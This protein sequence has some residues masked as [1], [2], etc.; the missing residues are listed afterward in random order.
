MNSDR[1]AHLLPDWQKSFPALLRPVIMH[2]EF[3]IAAAEFLTR[4]A[5][6]AGCERASL[7]FA[8]G[9][10]VKICA[11]SGI[12]QEAG[13]SI[14]PEVAAAMEE[15]LLQDAALLYPPATTGFPRIL[16]AHAELA[17]R[18]AVSHVLTVP[19]VQDTE[20]IGAITLE[21]AD[22]TNFLSEYCEVIETLAADAG[23]IL[24]LKW[25]LEQP[26]RV[27][28][29]EVLRHCLFGREGSMGHRMYFA[30]AMA[31]LCAL[32]LFMVPMSIAVTGQARLEADVQRILTAPID[33]Y[34]KEVRVRA[35]DR[36]KEHQ[37]LAELDGEALRGQQ[38]RLQAEIAQ[39]ENALMESMIRSDRAQVGIRRAR[40]DE[41]EA[42]K[43]LVD[44][45]LAQ[46]RLS[47]P[48]DGVV[49]KGDLSQLLG[50]PLKR[51]DVL[52]TLARG[53]GFRIIVEISEQDIA[54]VRV[55]QR[56]TLVLAALPSEEFAFRVVRLAP[57]ANITAD[58]NN[59]FEAEA[60]LDAGNHKLA[61]GLK[62]VAKITIGNR[63]LGWTWVARIWHVLSYAIWSKLG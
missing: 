12:Y 57:V 26:L 42:K 16:V 43:N 13:R 39:Q 53:K 58:G 35:G 30:V 28:V 33:G 27:R 4:L 51:S 18:N 49:I 5:E 19:L 54:D 1:A 59:V 60:L 62:G 11:V 40:L 44:Q 8:T 22:G 24:K 32:M 48:F 10:G 55:G 3:R 47:A 31:V 15:C 23:P 6:Y 45:Q 63:P 21:C 14:L 29:F 50:S 17:R 37:L 38:R 7:G 61:P 36:I 41:I 52:L 34:L 25:R 20:F 46:T 9:D 56:G 2:R